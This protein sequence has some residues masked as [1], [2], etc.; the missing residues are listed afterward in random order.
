MNKVKNIFSSW[1]CVNTRVLGIFRVFLG[2]ICFWDV[3]RRY[4]LID[5]FY[6]SSGINLSVG[7][8][9]T[10]VPQYFS[11]LHSFR[12]SDVMTVFFIITMITSFSLLIGYRT[13][14]SH[15]LTLVGVLSIHNY[16]IILEN[17]GDMA[18]NAFLVWSFFLPLGKSLS[19]D[20]LRKS[21]KINKE[22]SPE[23]LNRANPT[24][25]TEYYHLAYLAFLIQLCLIYTYNFINK[26]GDMWE[27]G[28]AVFHMY[29]LDT[30][31]TPFGFWFASILNPII[32]SLLTNSTIIMEWASIFLILSPIFTKWT[33]RVA[34]VCF[35][36]FHLMI[37]ISVSI[38]L[39]SWTMMTA[40]ILLLGYD[41][42]ALL[43]KFLST[44]STKNYIVFYDRDCGFCHFTARVLKRLD[45][46]KRFTWA[47]ASFRGKAPENFA[48]ILKNS[49]IV[50]DQNEDKYWTRHIA[51]SKIISSLPFGFLI[52]W[53]LRI[54][55]LEKI[56]G[57]IYDLFSQNRT[58]ISVFTGLPACGLPLPPV[59]ENESESPIS[60]FSG[61]IQK[62]SFGLS[63]VVAFVF[64]VGIINY[65][66]TANDGIEERFGKKPN[67]IKAYSH[68]LSYALKRTILYPRM[69]QKWNMFSPTV[70]RTERWVVADITFTD[71]TDTTLFVNSDDVY[72]KL[73][74]SHF[75]YRDQFWRKFFGRIHKKS[76]KKYIGEF[77][78]WLKRTKFFPEYR[79]RRPATVNLWQLSE[80]SPNIG[81]KKLPKVYK[82]K[83]ESTSNESKNR[84]RTTSK[85]PKNVG[86][87]K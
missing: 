25:N 67:G 1:F 17:G 7:T 56:F 81:A 47:D 65:S 82:R 2:V 10:Y 20:S 75:D 53:I 62:F 29:Q 31:L 34:L 26:T 4:H 37:G 66:L 30:F 33:R 74:Y 43:K 46:F 79:G 57:W 45:V 6:S 8:S 70:M 59:A 42:I 40:L 71:G 21:L 19:I 73:H 50:Y 68:D 15:F 14:L 87:K 5:V 35:M 28:T 13:K 41:D 78:R 16:R 69:S 77:K 11:L 49:I 24:E 61:Y 44:F 84:K 63:N 36:S 51:F 60:P 32:N 48:G 52:G 39:F 72:D 9:F 27:N 85:Y 12:S 54:P 22:Q 86:G 3:W 18:F 58:K 76:N 64:L 80:R 38:G 83:L 23:D 55:L